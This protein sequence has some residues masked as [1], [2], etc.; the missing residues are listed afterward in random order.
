MTA[1]VQANSL[2]LARH[3]QHFKDF[4]LVF[5]NFEFPQK[6][7]PWYKFWLYDYNQKE[8]EKC[9]KRFVHA[10]VAQELNSEFIECSLSQKLASAL[11]NLTQKG[12]KFKAS[13]CEFESRLLSAYTS[14]GP[15][16]T[17]KELNP[18]DFHLKHHLLG[19]YSLKPELYSHLEEN[20]PMLRSTLEKIIYKK[21]NKLSLTQEEEKCL[22]KFHTFLDQKKC[23]TDYYTVAVKGGLGLQIL[24]QQDQLEDGESRPSV[25]ILKVQRMRLLE[26]NEWA[27][28]WLPLDKWV[29]ADIDFFM[30]S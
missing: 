5:G 29:V 20:T 27:E 30:S 26:T 22:L 6:C 17:I 11:E 4:P 10:L 19:F 13:P 7:F 15:F 23:N 1:F 8:L 2:K 28:E 14:A 9:Y 21:K 25:H 3:M 16:C 24:N 12:Y 18:P